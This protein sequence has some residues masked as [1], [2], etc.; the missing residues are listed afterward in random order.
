MR[1]W[2]AERPTCPDQGK[3]IWEAAQEAQ[4][5]SHSW[6][7]MQNHWRR[8]LRKLNAGDPETQC[9]ASPLGDATQREQISQPDQMKCCKELFKLDPS[10]HCEAENIW[11]HR[12][13]EFPVTH[14]RGTHSDVA[15]KF[16]N[17]AH[18]GHPIGALLEALKTAKTTPADI[19]CL[20]A[21]RQWGELFVVFGNR[22]LTMLKRYAEFLHRPVYM[23]VIVHDMPNPDIQP[24]DLERSFISKFI[25]ACTTED[26]GLSAPMRQYRPQY[27]Y[28][29]PTPKA[30]FL[31][32][33]LKVWSL[34]LC[35]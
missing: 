18:G 9:R 12:M 15:A 34:G 5:T 21:D 30:F 28:A 6:Q 1:Q 23:R 8:C 16:K 26:G 17:G 22:R 29:S 20:V 35:Y 4:V 33:F 3:K 11:R 2:V 7:S 14:L 19:P 24:P 31:S 25:L 13:Q 27:G 10:Q 32:F